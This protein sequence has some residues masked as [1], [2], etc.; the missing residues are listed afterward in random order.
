M[1]GRYSATFPIELP[2]PRSM[3]SE[4]RR[5]WLSIGVVQEDKAADKRYSC[6]SVKQAEIFPHGLNRAHARSNM[7]DRRPLAWL[8]RQE[9]IDMQ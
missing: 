6:W 7:S 8:H 4:K 1:Q 9:R 3:E 5:K 2:E